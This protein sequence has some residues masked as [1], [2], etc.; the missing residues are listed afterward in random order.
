MGG[1]G[2]AAAAQAGT[3]AMSSLIGNR[4]QRRAAK[5]QRRFNE[6]QAQIS[7]E[8]NSEEAQRA[9]TFTERMSSTAYQRAS[10]DL[11]A[12]GLNRI[13]AF[14]SPANT[15]GGSAASGT[16]ASGGAAPQSFDFGNPVGTAIQA[17]QAK[18][19]IAN[20]VQS[21]ATGIAT[22]R[23]QNATAAM[24][25][26]K[27]TVEKIK[28]DLYGQGRKWFEENQS[29]IMSVL[30]TAWKQAT[31]KTP[32][33][34]GPRSMFEKGKKVWDYYQDNEWKPALQRWGPKGTKR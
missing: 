1:S 8:F 14:G 10:R 23:N 13:L 7:R 22:E 4:A 16:A 15:P 28:G 21:T 11:E 9:R 29:E 27:T 32:Q 33:N 30:N 19:S 34:K 6:E 26:A 18:A 20:T 17:A 24:T 25:E 5:K 12:A 2:W 31:T 3:G